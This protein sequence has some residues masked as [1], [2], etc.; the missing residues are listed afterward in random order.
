MHITLETDYAVR[1]V[2]ALTRCGKRLDARA[3]SEQTRVPQRFALKIL[4]KLVADGI[5]CS[6]KGSGGGYELARSPGEIT[7][8]E[9]IESV[10]GPY[11]ISRCQEDAYCCDHT[12]CR[13]HE[14][15]GEIS[16]QVRQKLDSYTF[17][18]ICLEE[19]ARSC[20]YDCPGCQQHGEGKGGE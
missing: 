13:F 5:I 4:R 20:G 17:A 10:E 15:Y 11:R 2:E 12:T 16:Q 6:Y 18:A 8:R 19:G 7:L 14:I 3:L 9:V 1:I